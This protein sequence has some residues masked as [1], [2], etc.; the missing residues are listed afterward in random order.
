MVG[1]PGRMP[2]PGKVLKELYLEARGWTQTDLARKIGCS[3]KKVNQVV[4][5]RSGISADFAIDLGKALDTSAQMWI[6]MQADYD[7]FV[8]IEKRK[9]A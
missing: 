5:G 7:L 6:R 2:H 8:A 3:S 1:M 4:N 9:S